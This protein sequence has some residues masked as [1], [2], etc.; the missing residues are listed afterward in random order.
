[1]TLD[2]ISVFSFP[3]GLV[4]V[5]AGAMSVLVTGVSTALVN[6]VLYLECVQ[7]LVEGTNGL[8]RN[9]LYWGMSCGTFGFSWEFWR[10]SV[11][12]G[13]WLHFIRQTC[14]LAAG[15]GTNGWKDPFARLSMY[16]HL[17]SDGWSTVHLRR[18]VGG[19]TRCPQWW[20]Q[21][22]LVVNVS[23]HWASHNFGLIHSVIRTS[24]SSLLTLGLFERTK[25]LLQSYSL[26]YFLDIWTG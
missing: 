12:S 18:D 1:M 16:Y 20:M 25:T 3:A 2:C 4:A 7:F 19:R 21:Y 17:S 11:N 10:Y 15:A 24:S 14:L 23:K 5:T 6:S 9:S 13:G 26:E 8:W 22:V